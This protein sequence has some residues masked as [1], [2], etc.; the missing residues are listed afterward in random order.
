MGLFDKIKNA[1]F[2]EEEIEEEEKSTQEEPVIEKEKKKKEV[3]IENERD[4]FKA[5]A[6]FSWP[7][8]DEQEFEITKEKTK[9]EKKKKED[10]ILEEKTPRRSFGTIDY[11]NKKVREKRK[12]EKRDYR[13]ERESTIKEEPHHEFRP[14]PVISPV[15]GILDKNYKK[16]DLVVTKSKETKGLDVDQVRKKAFGAIENEIEKEEKVRKFE[17]AILEKPTEESPIED[18]LEDA[19]DEAIDLTSELKFEDT[20]ELTKDLGLVEEEK[21]LSRAKMHENDTL[22]ILDKEPKEKN[23]DEDTLESDL[24]DLIDS[25]YENREDDE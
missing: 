7:E 12:E 13:K 5:E 2:V 1:L 23:I 20:L 25:M 19:A 6:T 11:D 18:L 4:L 22:E 9:E 14:T 17:D 3:P 16:E 8:F 21:S 24:F 10:P 15:Y